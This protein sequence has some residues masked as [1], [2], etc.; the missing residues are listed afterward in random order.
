MEKSFKIFLCSIAIFMLWFSV[1][2]FESIDIFSYTNESIF[3]WLFICIK[4]GLAFLFVLI[5]LELMLYVLLY[6]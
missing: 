5:S 2:I 1:I 3:I 4:I 6:N